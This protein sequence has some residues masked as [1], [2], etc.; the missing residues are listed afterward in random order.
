LTPLHAPSTTSPG[1]QDAHTLNGIDNVGGCNSVW[2]PFSRI[3]N[4]ITYDGQHP[5]CPQAAHTLGPLA[6]KLHRLNNKQNFGVIKA[7]SPCGTSGQSEK[8]FAGT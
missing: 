4:Y 7:P 5:C 1:T 2:S 6:H 8:L 3:V